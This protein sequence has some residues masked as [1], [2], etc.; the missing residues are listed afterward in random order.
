MSKKK[1]AAKPHKESLVIDSSIACAWCFPDERGQ[2]QNCVRK[3]I[4][5]PLPRER[6]GVRALSQASAGA[7]ESGLRSG[8]NIQFPSSPLPGTTPMRQK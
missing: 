8:P 4:R 1:G 7:K 2:T 5:L 6:A 3:K